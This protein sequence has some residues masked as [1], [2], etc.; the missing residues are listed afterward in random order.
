MK[1]HRT[2]APIFALLATLAAAAPAA[3]PASPLLSGYGG[4]GL[5]NQAILG[6]ALLNGNASAGGGSGPASGQGIGAANIPTT[7]GHGATQGRAGL[8]VPRGAAAEGTGGKVSG[9]ASNAYPASEVGGAASA[10]TTF[11][12]SG[13]DILFILLAL[14]VLAL[15]GVLTRRLITDTRREHTS[16]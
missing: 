11:G 9:V 2:I 7:A 5:G 6:S 16:G 1:R 12:L 13:Q 14:L 8:R 4:P 15:T 10:S 3:A